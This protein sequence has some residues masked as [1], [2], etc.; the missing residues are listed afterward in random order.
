MDGTEYNP[1]FS[2]DAGFRSVRVSYAGI[3]LGGR[4]SNIKS[5]VVVQADPDCEVRCVGCLGKKCCGVILTKLFIV[6]MEER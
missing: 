6:R 3:P 1:L 5:W 4:I 2:W